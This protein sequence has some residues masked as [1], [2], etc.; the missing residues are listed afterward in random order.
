MLK[1]LKVVVARSNQLCLDL[2][3]GQD[4][5]RIRPPPLDGFQCP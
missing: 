5:Y 4:L 2:R 3:A 1:L